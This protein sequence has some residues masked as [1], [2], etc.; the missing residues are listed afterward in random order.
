MPVLSTNLRKRLMVN[1][2][3]SNERIKMIAKEI[4]SVA[5]P[6]LISERVS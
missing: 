1:H 6:P 2:A 3:A 4:T 5:S